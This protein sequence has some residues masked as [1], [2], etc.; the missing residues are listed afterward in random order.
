VGAVSVLRAP[1][2]SWI[3]PLVRDL[4]RA[5]ADVCASPNHAAHALNTSSLS[6]PSPPHE[7]V[8]ST[9]MLEVYNKP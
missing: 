7:Q 3:P 4:F 9:D 8:S 6:F 5:D 1:S 2:L